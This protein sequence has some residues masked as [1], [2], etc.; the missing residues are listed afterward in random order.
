VISKKSPE[1]TTYISQY[2]F[3]VAF[4]FSN[5]VGVPIDSF[6]FST[7]REL[8]RLSLLDVCTL[9]LHFDNFIREWARL[10]GEANPDDVR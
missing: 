4:D 5:P 2:Q 7:T 9:R 3:Q 1:D 8:K 6:G 10:N